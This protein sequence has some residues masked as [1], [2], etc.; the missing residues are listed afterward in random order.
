MGEHLV[1]E[2]YYWFDSQVRAKKY[3]NA[4]S[5][6]GFFE[7]SPKTAQRSIDFMRDRLGAPL[8]YHSGKKGYAY[9]G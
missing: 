3:P 7:I 2:R 5:L 9:Y 1:L 8:E 6:A 4:T